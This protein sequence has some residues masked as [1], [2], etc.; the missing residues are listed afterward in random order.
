M[1]KGTPAAVVGKLR[2]ASLAALTAGPTADKLRVLGA[3]PV[4]GDRMPS[5]R[6]P[7]FISSEISKWQTIIKQAGIRLD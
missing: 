5:D 1:P 2:E 3:E 7:A 6:L 4:A